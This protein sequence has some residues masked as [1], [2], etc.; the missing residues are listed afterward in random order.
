MTRGLSFFAIGLVFFVP[1]IELTPSKNI[2]QRVDFIE[3]SGALDAQALSTA[4]DELGPPRI[5]RLLPM[6]IAAGE[7]LDIFGAGFT[8]DSA[9]FLDRRPLAIESLNPTRLRVRI[10]DPASSG[11]IMLKNA[12]GEVRFERLEVVPYY[13]PPKIESFSP[14]VVQ[15]GGLLHIRGSGFGEENRTLYL[16]IGGELAEILERRDDRLIARV[17]EG[18]KTGTLILVVAR[19]G[20]AIAQLPVRVARAH[21]RGEKK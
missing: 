4:T 17:P 9:V 13:P 16:S 11:V 3:R 20:Q 18:A 6:V 7:S 15:A 12:Y 1:I 5:D 2:A 21:E 19:G 14:D 10:P 8:E